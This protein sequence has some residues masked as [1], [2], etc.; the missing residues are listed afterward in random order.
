MIKC[1]FSAIVLLMCHILSGQENQTK[2]INDQ[3]WIP[4]VR[5]FS[6]GD[7]EAFKSVHSKD[8]IRVE[9]DG[10]RIFGHDI[11]LRKVPD[12]VKAIW[13]KWTKKIELRFIQRI[14]GDGKAF[15]IGYYR[16]TSNN[17]ETG[18][19]RVRIGKFHVLL[20]KENGVWKILMDADTSVDASEEKF[21][22]AEPM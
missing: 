6:N 3:V 2:E 7:E 12:S 14:A 22:E 9:Q 19:K 20:R 13:S 17:I 11:Y 21:L 10:K 15:E 1:I 16:T 8:V 18:E 5:S 4:F